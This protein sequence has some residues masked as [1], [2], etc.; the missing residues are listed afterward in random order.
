MALET[1]D[2]YELLRLEINDKE[3]PGNGDSSLS[4]WSNEE[5]YHYIDEAHR[6]FAR[7]T[8]CLLDATT[9]D[10]VAITAG[11]AW[12]EFDERIV[13]LRRVYLNS[14]GNMVEFMTLND[15]ERGNV[16]AAD[17]GAQRLNSSWKQTT[18]TPSVLITDME[19]GKGRLYPIPSADDSLEMIV[20]REPLYEIED[21]NTDLE[22][23]SKFR[24]ALIN[25]AAMQAYSKDDVETYNGDA[26]R[27][28][29]SLWEK[30]KQDALSFFR[31]KIRRAPVTTYGGI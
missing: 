30:A 24:R 5:L 3:L 21:T 23:D 2:I 19:T 29:A 8:L 14:T 4:L 1:C 7:D 9:F 28:H 13:E 26:I 10:A 15:F 18:G 12:V 22:I 11:S 17:Y 20:Y 25:G 16:Y 31:K 6:E 27:Y